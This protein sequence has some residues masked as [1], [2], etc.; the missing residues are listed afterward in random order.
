MAL[1]VFNPS[2]YELDENKVLQEIRNLLNSI[3]LD[4]QSEE[5][6]IPKCL[7]NMEFQQQE[8]FRDI[9]RLK[10]AIQKF[11]KSKN[12]NALPLKL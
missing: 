9:I 10:H 4:T 3:L 8:N 11:L 2:E 12:C 6:K 1:V 5:D 7:K